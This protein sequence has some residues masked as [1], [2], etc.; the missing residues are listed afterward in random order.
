VPAEG[1]DAVGGEIAGSSSIKGVV[2][3]AAAVPSGA[4]LDA[5]ELTVVSLMVRKWLRS[6]SLML[7]TPEGM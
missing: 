6:R 2:V 7:D 4:E 5:T 1:G 3:V